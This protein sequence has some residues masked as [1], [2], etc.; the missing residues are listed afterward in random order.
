MLLDVKIAL[1]I[2]KCKLQ[3]RFYDFYNPPDDPFYPE[4]NKLT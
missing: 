1:K 2:G 4:L 3:V